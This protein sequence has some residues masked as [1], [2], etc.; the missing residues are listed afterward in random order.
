LSSPAR[1]VTT[2]ASPRNLVHL[3]GIE[4]VCFWLQIQL[5]NHSSA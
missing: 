2:V 1:A 5:T 3:T 4:P